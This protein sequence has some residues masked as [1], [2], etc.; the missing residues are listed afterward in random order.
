MEHVALG[1]SQTESQKLMFS[2]AN[3]Q[4]HAYFEPHSNNIKCTD[5][6]SKLQT[7]LNSVQY[8][9]DTSIPSNSNLSLEN[10]SYSVTTNTLKMQVPLSKMLN[11]HCPF[12]PFPGI[13]MDL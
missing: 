3:S 8:S 5:C 6:I 11:F 12:S 1:K 4:V 7:P 10:T 9:T 2:T 13:F